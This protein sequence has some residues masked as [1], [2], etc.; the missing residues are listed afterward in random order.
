MT[1]QYNLKQEIEAFIERNRYTRRPM[2]GGEMIED[3]LT[4]E[5]Y[6]LSMVLVMVFNRLDVIEQ[7][8]ESLKKEKE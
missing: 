5:R 2:P 3:E 7:E 1:E 4:G 6:P 8:I